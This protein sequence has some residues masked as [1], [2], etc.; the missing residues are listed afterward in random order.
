MISQLPRNIENYGEAKAFLATLAARERPFLQQSFARERTRFLLQSIGNPDKQMQCIHI[1][2]TSGKGTV[3]TVVAHLLHGLGFKVGLETSPYISDMRERVWL[4]GRLISVEEI[5][6]GLRALLPAIIQLETSDKGW[7]GYFEVWT[8]LGFYIFA[9]QEITHAV[10]ETGIGGLRSATNVLDAESKLAVITKIGLDHMAQLGKT[11]KKI[12]QQKA[13]IIHP[14]N[15]VFLLGQTAAVEAIIQERCRAEHAA[16]QIIRGK[17]Y[18]KNT[19]LSPQGM[20]FDYSDNEGELKRLI[21][22][23]V[24][25]HQA[26][27]LALA[28]MVVKSICRRVGIAWNEETV[29]ETLARLFIAGRFE[30]R[31]KERQT[32]VF[33]IAHNPQKMRSLVQTLKK[34]WPK[35]AFTFLIAFGDA[36]DHVGMLRALLPIVEQVVFTDFLVES[37]EYPFRFTDADG[38]QKR[39][40]DLGFTSVQAIKDDREKAL[41]AALDLVSG[42]LIITGNTSFVGVMRNHILCST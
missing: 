24:G 33:D 16:L 19:S 7:A 22:P 1:A 21:T 35:Q 30:V 36:T 27:N 25:F 23:L 18:V 14:Y 5:V 11:I 41:W 40:Q 15:E 38:L 3:A 6:E 37:Q 39:A 9:K 26:E 12:A 2:G 29:R 32:I 4:Q 8:V 20:I 42:P 10:I 34:V 13:G 17:D 28:F 31:I